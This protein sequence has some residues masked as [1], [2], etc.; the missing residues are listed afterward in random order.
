VNTLDNPQIEKFSYMLLI[1]LT[2]FSFIFALSIMMMGG[3]IPTT[4]IKESVSNTFAF[5]AQFLNHLP[6]RMFA[7]GILVIL[8]ISRFKISFSV[9]KKTTILPEELDN[10]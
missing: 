5:V 1:P 6:L 10:I 9:S 3:H 4:T 8:L 2:L 7:H